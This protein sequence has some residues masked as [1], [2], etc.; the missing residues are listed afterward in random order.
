MAVK[1]N[2]YKSDMFSFGLVMLTSASLKS[3]SELNNNEQILVNRI[4]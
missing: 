3:T 4:N 2:A 1:H